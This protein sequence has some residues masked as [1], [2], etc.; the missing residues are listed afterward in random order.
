MHTYNH[1]VET[2]LKGWGD[3]VEVTLYHLCGNTAVP[4][5]YRTSLEEIRYIYTLLTLVLLKLA[6]ANLSHLLLNAANFSWIG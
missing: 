2:S 5:P 3:Q 4:K 6:V 1:F